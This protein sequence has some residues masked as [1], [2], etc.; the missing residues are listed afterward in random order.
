MNLRINIFTVIVFGWCV[1]TSG[2]LFGGTVDTVAIPNDSESVLLRQPDESLQQDVYSDKDYKYVTEDERSVNE[3]SFF[4]RY[5]GNLFRRMFENDDS[6]SDPSKSDSVNWWAILIIC[7][8][9]GMLVFFIIKAT[10]AG[11]NSLFKGKSKRKEK[12]DA[13]VEEI[14]IHG[15]DYD[16]E[17]SA[18]KRRSD[19]RLAVRL[20][21]LRSLK[22]MTDLKLIDWKI[23]KTNSDYYYELSGSRLQKDFASISLLYE[24]VWYGDFEIMEGRY[25]E[26]ESKLQNYYS[27]IHQNAPLK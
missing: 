11:G 4:E 25:G 27:S 18:A 16:A 15:I 19:Y 12:L 20:W 3:E 1:F 7:I 23:D 8:G 22:E 14:D 9:G 24:Y 13:T 21:F 6:D 5:F 17:I 2:N 26:V 10:G